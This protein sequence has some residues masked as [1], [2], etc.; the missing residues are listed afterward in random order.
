MHIESQELFGYFD[1]YRKRQVE[2]LVNNSNPDSFL[3]IQAKIRAADEIK[4][5]ILQTETKRRKAL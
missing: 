3:L 5:H 1:S 2:A 4:D